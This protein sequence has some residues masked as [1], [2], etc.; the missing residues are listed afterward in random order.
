VWCCGPRSDFF[1]TGCEGFS[2]P[3]IFSAVKLIVPEQIRNCRGATT[4]IGVLC[5]HSWMILNFTTEGRASALKQKRENQGVTAARILLVDDFEPCRTLVS[6]I[7]QDQPGYQIVGES[8][9]GPEAVRTAEALSPDLVVLDMGFPGF[10]GIEVAREIQ[11]CSPSSIIL[12]LTGNHDRERARQALYAGAMG[13]VHKFDVVAELA[14][15]ASAV[16]AG[17]RFVSRRFR[18]L[19]V[20]ANF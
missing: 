4:G 6:L 11:S 13:Y 17:M 12:F 2:I 8:C 20:S 14:A 7:L 1:C 3:A 16:L 10:D 19:G 18:N 15:A 5:H 9:N